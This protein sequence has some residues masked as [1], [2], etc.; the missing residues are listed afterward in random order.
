S[1][2]ARSVR[3]AWSATPPASSPVLPPGSEPAGA[4][5]AAARPLRPPPWPPRL[6]AVAT[7]LLRHPPQRPALPESNGKQR[8]ILPHLNQRPSAKRL[9]I[10]PSACPRTPVGRVGFHRRGC[11][12]ITPLPPAC[13][14]LSPA[15]QS[16]SV[17][18]S[19]TSSSGPIA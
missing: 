4:P 8:W 2:A 16:V 14:S 17:S 3:S 5:P 10:R 15:V 11:L 12:R 18:F 7:C 9:S 6:A 13:G 1:P 19:L